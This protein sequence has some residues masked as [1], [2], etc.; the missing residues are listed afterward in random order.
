MLRIVLFFIFFFIFSGCGVATLT[1]YSTEMDLKPNEGVLVYATSLERDVLSYDEYINGSIGDVNKSLGFKEIYLFNHKTRKHVLLPNTF[2]KVNA[3]RIP[4]G[5]YELARI[6]YKA[7]RTTYKHLPYY[8]LRDKSSLIFSVKANTISFLNLD[9][10]TKRID[11][12]AGRFEFVEDFTSIMLNHTENKKSQAFIKSSPS[13]AT[14]EK[15]SAENT[16]AFFFDKKYKHDVVEVNGKKSLILV[17]TSAEC[18]FAT[19]ADGIRS[20]GFLGLSMLGSL[21]YD[22][23]LHTRELILPE[24]EY[25]RLLE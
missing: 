2:G 22:R 20:P 7:E 5:R 8:Y 16:Y 13:L 4:E 21:E 23:L 11:G 10:V 6:T 1:P 19:N 25:K 3:V 18:Y 17:P 24:E 14:M 9:A 15:L 12:P